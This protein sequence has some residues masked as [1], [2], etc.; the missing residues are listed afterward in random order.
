MAH[1]SP[2][3]R[4]SLIPTRPGAREAASTSFIL[5]VDKRNNNWSSLVNGITFPS[6]V[7]FFFLPEIIPTEEMVSIQQQ[8]FPCLMEAVL[9]NASSSSRGA[10]STEHRVRLSSAGMAWRHPRFGRQDAQAP[11]AIPPVTKVASLAGLLHTEAKRTSM[12]EVL[13]GR[14]IRPQ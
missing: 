12:D 2:L 6:V 5:P 4:G 3:V 10:G 7:V 11:D 1:M 13:K 8:T 9:C 14:S